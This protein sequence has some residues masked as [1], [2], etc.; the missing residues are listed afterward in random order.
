MNESL[1]HEP[2]NCYAL[3]RASR[4]VTQLYDQYLA[5]YGLTVSQYALVARLTRTGP[6]SIHQLAQ[7][8]VMDR[9]TLARNLKPLER[10]GLVTL[11]LDAND[12]RSKSVAVTEQGRSL[13]RRARPA[14]EAAQ[15]QFEEAFGSAR[16]A[17]LRDLLHAAAEA[18]LLSHPAE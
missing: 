2:C 17:Q 16:A 7:E 9:T 10:D 4:H 8:L 14:W 15:R 11:E 18:E 5:P 6:R 13:L 12:R 3:R 1:P